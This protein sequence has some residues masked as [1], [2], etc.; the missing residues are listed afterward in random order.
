MSKKRIMPDSLLYKIPMSV[1]TRKAMLPNEA[2]NRL[3]EGNLRFRGDK[4]G[5]AKKPRTREKGHNKNEFIRAS[6]PPKGQNPFAIVL[7][8]VD[9]RVPTEVIFDQEI[10]DIFNARIAGNFVNEDILG[11]MEF[12]ASYVKLIVVLGHT[13]CGAIAA[14]C[15]TVYPIPLTDKETTPSSPPPPNLAQLVGKLTPIASIT[16]VDESKIKKEVKNS[17]YRKDFINRAAE[18]NV[19]GTVTDILAKSKFLKEKVI[20]G[21]LGIVGAMYDV[22]T[23]EVRFPNHLIQIMPDKDIN[24]Q[25]IA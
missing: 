12:A 15:N 19:R 20:S 1:S 9:S 18:T 13:S 24:P 11:S 22:S 8:C 3:E 16:A 7:S 2:L 14:A 25:K 4:S 17:P 21:E 5:G 23:G 10:G 6:A